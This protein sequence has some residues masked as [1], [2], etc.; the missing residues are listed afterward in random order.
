MYAAFCESSCPLIAGLIDCTD[1]LVINPF[2]LCVYR[3]S[4]VNSYSN[5]KGAV[6][7]LPDDSLSQFR[8][9]HSLYMAA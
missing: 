8:F 4:S 3:S 2:F 6:H 5:S 9:R 1:G 7:D